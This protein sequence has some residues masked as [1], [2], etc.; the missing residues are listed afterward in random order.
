MVISKKRYLQGFAILV[1]VL[2]VIRAVRDERANE[3]TPVAVVEG[4][5]LALAASEDTIQEEEQKA[6]E[7]WEKA[8]ERKEM[9]AGESSF[10]MPMFNS[11]SART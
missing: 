4:D 1:I 11:L 3:R 2:A 5:S 8:Q 7:A 6:L 10:S 9:K